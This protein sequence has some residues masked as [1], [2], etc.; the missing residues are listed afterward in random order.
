MT[1]LPSEGAA[2]ESGSGS[3]TS[4]PA[5]G[6]EILE[7][8][9]LASLMALSTLATG[10]RT[11]TQTLTQVAHFAVSAIEADGAGL[12]LFED[13]RPNTVVGTADFVDSIDS[14]EHAVGEGPSISSAAERQTIRSGSLG[15]ERRWP[16]FGPRVGRLGVHSVLSLP[17]LTPN[18]VLGTMNIYA[19]KKHAF[20]ERSEH[21]G[22]MFAVPAAIAVQNAQVLEEAKRLAASLQSALTTR[23][24]VE[25]ALGIMRSR[26]GCSSEEAYRR[27]RVMSQSKNTKL[28]AVA[29]SVV[30]EAVRRAVARQSSGKNP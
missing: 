25:Q 18:G 29:Q 15:G 8:G 9:L 2:R 22:Q 14:I 24:V 1:E 27:L 12:T 13:R 21:R 26:S 23:A 6:Q 3:E 10:Q 7:E 28:V 16:R 19:Y 17:L 20:D 4:R 30:D 11:L 5:G